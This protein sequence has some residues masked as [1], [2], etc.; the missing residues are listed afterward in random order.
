M[1]PLPRSGLKPRLAPAG[2]SLEVLFNHRRLAER[3][4]LMRS[5]GYDVTAGVEFVVAQALPLAGCVLE[6]GTGKGRFMIALAPHVKT[7]TTVDISPEEQQF[8][9]RTARLAGVRTKIKYILQDA[10]TL[11]WPDQTFDAVVTMNAMHH[12]SH[13]T[14]VL[15]EMQR[16]VK[17]GG[18]LVLADLSPRGFQIMARFHRS[19]GTIHERHCHDFH[20]FQKH[21]R[22]RGWA[23]RLEKGSLQEV[24]VANSPAIPSLEK[25]A[26]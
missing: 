20:D 13:F 4:A 9:R 18:K 22:D 1:A 6:I 12:I 26:A 8:A 11:P 19:E 5:F 21:L 2:H 7:L 3:D 24:L 25:G 23:T 15:E 10:V 17:P 14:Q 16:V